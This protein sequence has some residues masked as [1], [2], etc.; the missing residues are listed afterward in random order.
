M[1]RFGLV[2]SVILIAGVLASC[3]LSFQFWSNSSTHSL[4]PGATA[5]YTV[6]VPSDQLGP[7]TV[8]FEL[9]KNLNMVVYESNGSEYA[10]TS[11][12]DYFATGSLA[13][14]SVSG[15]GSSLSPQAIQPGAA[16]K[17]SCIIHAADATSFD[18]EITNQT[19]STVSFNFD[20]YTAP[21]K[22]SNEP[23]NDQLSTGT[24]LYSSSQLD[25]ALETINDIDYFRVHDSG[26]L[27][28]S[29][30]L[31]NGTPIIDL[32]AYV[33]TSGGSPVAT[34]S[35]GSSASVIPGDYALVASMSGNF[36]APAS[37]C[38]YYVQL[39]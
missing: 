1:R 27:T 24:N 28:F 14:S 7:R 35:P 12:P 5:T 6:S 2:A 10:G 32:R 36:A 33:Y 18:V 17:G 30:C 39:Q 9:D 11:S 34:L 22:D 13:L 29:G 4:A 16:C 31:Y 3:T 37:S 26:S 38:I 19:S 8:H 20:A 23:G 21:Y 25:G 15:S